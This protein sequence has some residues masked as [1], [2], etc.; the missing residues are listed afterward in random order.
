MIKQR[1]LSFGVNKLGLGRAHIA[2]DSGLRAHNA[3]GRVQIIR[4]ALLSA[5]LIR[6]NAVFSKLPR[7]QVAL[8][9]ALGAVAPA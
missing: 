2:L 1:L 3:H 9:K 5:Q 6:T 7:R 8:A 4:H